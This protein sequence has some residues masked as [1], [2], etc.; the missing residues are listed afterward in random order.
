M[1]RKIDALVAEHVMGLKNVRHTTY[2]D[3]HPD[4]Q[5]EGYFYD[6]RRINRKRSWPYTDEPVWLTKL[7][8][9]PK[10]TRTIAT[11]WKVVEKLKW[12]RAIRF[13]GQDVYVQAWD[14]GGPATVEVLNTS[15]PMAIC[16]AALK[17]KGVEAP[18]A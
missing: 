12:I 15:A 6:K 9:V 1:S 7:A 11:A 3:C 14:D 13:E 2:T 17:A 5:Y 10:Y 8:S 18:D 4:D 16:L